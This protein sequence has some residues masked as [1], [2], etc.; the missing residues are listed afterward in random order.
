MSLIVCFKNPRI[1]KLYHETYT[2]KK[3]A[4]SKYA[5]FFISKINLSIIILSI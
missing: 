5:A 2:S 1:E 3:A 4:Y